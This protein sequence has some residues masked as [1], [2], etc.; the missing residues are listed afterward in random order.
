MAFLDSAL[1]SGLGFFSCGTRAK[2]VHAVD[3]VAY[4]F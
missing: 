2:A 4:G 1:N 3:P